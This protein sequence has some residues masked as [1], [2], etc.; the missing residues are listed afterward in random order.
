MERQHD[1]ELLVKVV[2]EQQVE[3]FA[4][5]L[6]ATPTEPEVVTGS[7]DIL[8]IIDPPSSLKRNLPAILWAVGV[9]TVSGLAIFVS[10]IFGW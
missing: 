4:A 2:E 6:N 3:R 7:V 8:P 5:Q 9:V 10:E 1:V